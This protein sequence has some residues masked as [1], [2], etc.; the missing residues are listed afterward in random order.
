MTRAHVLLIIAAF[1]AAIY[2]PGLG[3]AELKGEEGRRIL[4]AITML[5][6]GNWVVPYIGGEPY[7]RKPPLVNWM[8]ASSFAMTGERNEWSARLPLVLCVLALGLTIGG[9]CTRW[10]GARTAVAAALFSIA[11]VAMI[12]KGRLA[13]IEALYVALSGI[14]MVLWLAWSEQGRSRWLVWSIPFLFNGLALLAKG[15][16]HLLFFYAVV[17]ATP[18]GRRELFS[19]PHLVGLLLMGG[20]FAAWAVPYFKATAALRSAG[21]GADASGVWLAQIMER[22]GGGDFVPGDWALSLPRGLSNFLPWVLLVPL[23][24]KQPSREPWFRHVR[25]VVTAAY[26]GFLL[27]PGFLPRYT[28]PLLVPAALLLAVTLR[29]GA[30]P[31]WHRIRSR[32]NT[33]RVPAAADLGIACAGAALAALVILIYAVLLTPLLH[34]YDDVRPLGEGIAAT[35]PEGQSLYVYDIEFEPAMFYVRRPVR[36]EAKFERLPQDLPWVLAKEKELPKF[37]RNYRQLEERAEF[38]NR[39][40]SKL[41]LLSASGKKR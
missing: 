20:I 16:A 4:P 31:W 39:D 18:R 26:I 12:E 27:I 35:V 23:W 22:L 28:M 1:W 24:W 19:L 37:K 8:I 25:N 14:A 29:D 5:E 21:E 34:R 38:R 40:G 13:E 6:T 9:V 15:P 36:Y 10:L 3:S 30:F 7:L 17:L 32:L 11:N 41:K 33:G 2:L